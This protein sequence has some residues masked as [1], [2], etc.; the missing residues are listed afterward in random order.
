MRKYLSEGVW[1]KKGSPA[2][3][4]SIPEKTDVEI[5]SAAQGNVDDI[6]TGDIVV[7]LAGGF[8]RQVARASC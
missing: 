6:A 4:Y 5:I 2:A 8:A 1:A 3:E 7:C